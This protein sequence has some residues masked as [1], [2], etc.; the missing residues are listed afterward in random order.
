MLANKI[1]FSVIEHLS[2]Y[3]KRVALIKSWN[4]QVNKCRRKAVKDPYYDRLADEWQKKI[5]G[6][7]AGL[8]L[9]E[10]QGKVKVRDGKPMTGKQRIKY[11]KEQKR[12]K[13]EELLA[14]HQRNKKEKIN[15]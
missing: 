1:D 11:K 3:E 8:P 5:D 14:Q 2:D 7:L 6:C 4:G 10:V 12:K 9:S 15:E 13:H